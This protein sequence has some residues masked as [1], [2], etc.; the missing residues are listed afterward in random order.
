LQL[1]FKPESFNRLF[2]AVFRRRA[3]Q[4]WIDFCSGHPL[5]G[6]FFDAIHF[7]SL[8][9]QGQVRQHKNGF[10]FWTAENWVGYYENSE[11]RDRYYRDVGLSGEFGAFH[12]LHFAVEGLNFFVGEHSPIHDVTTRLACAQTVWSAC[13]LRFRETVRAQEEHY[14]RLLAASPE[15]LN[16]L[17]FLVQK[18]ECAVKQALAGFEAILAVFSAD[19]GAKYG[20][21]FRR[22]IARATVTRT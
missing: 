4:P 9:V 21:Y 19:L 15:A 7:C 2:F 1:A 8:V 11:S 14:A 18:E 5:V 22:S 6:A 13:M 16:A 20:T 10:Y 3:M 12:D 17:R